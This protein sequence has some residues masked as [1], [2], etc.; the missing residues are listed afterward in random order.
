MTA[1]NSPPS[2]ADFSASTHLDASPSIWKVSRGDGARSSAAAARL[3]SHL[4]RGS[5]ARTVSGLLARF[6]HRHASDIY[7][8][9]ES[10]AIIAD[11]VGDR[12][13]RPRETA[14]SK[15]RDP[16]EE[17]EIPTPIIARDGAGACVHS[18][19]ENGHVETDLRPRL[20]RYFYWR[21]FDRALRLLR[22]QH[23]T[24]RSAFTRGKI[25]P[26]DELSLSIR[27]A[28]GAWS[29]KN[30]RQW[31]LR[32]KSLMARETFEISYVKSNSFQCKWNIN[33][34]NLRNK[35]H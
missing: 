11:R 19:R 30:G 9:S 26:K 17:S 3:E 8:I 15:G 7:E 20:L 25:A 2:R 1:R 23:Y 14:V 27:G 16:T 18:W 5:P 35:L 6:V 34:Y 13:V 32:Q 28:L 10:R 29:F 22:S 31:H 21:K 33:F 12:G 24:L 4:P